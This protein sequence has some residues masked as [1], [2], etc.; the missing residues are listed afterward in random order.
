VP[1]PLSSRMLQR[2]KENL[3]PLS[4]PQPVGFR[5]IWFNEEEDEQF[6]VNPEDVLLPENSNQI[7]QRMS[8]QGGPRETL[9]F[10][11]SVSRLPRWAQAKVTSSNILPSDLKFNLSQ[12]L[13]CM[14]KSPEFRFL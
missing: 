12:V 14:I 13:V 2:M 3:G 11:F 4:L 7:R 5:Q 9:A 1:V 6:R 8:Y 10:K